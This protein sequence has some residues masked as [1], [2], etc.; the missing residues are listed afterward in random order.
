MET[1]TQEEP[2]YEEVKV[3]DLFLM[4][5]GRVTWIS[6]VIEV[7]RNQFILRSLTALD[8]SLDSAYWKHNGHRVAEYGSEWIESPATE[9]D[10]KAF[11][12]QLA[13]EKS[14]QEDGEHLLRQVNQR[15][16]DIVAPLR[17][18]VWAQN[19][20]AQFHPHEKD[21]FCYSITFFGLAE[22]QAREIV[23]LLTPVTS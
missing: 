8:D 6:K 19:V 22:D 4:D 5:R 17:S 20:S 13:D 3:G 12:K 9:R 7:S 21:R 23:R 1:R 18:G 11:Y 10:V 15:V 16:D 2:K 14:V